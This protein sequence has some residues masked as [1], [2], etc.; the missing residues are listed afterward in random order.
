MKILWSNDLPVHDSSKDALRSYLSSLEVE[1]LDPYYFVGA[2]DF[3]K[4]VEFVRSRLSAPRTHVISDS[5]ICG[6]ESAGLKLLQQLRAEPNFGKGIVLSE[7]LH[8]SVGDPVWQTQRQ[9]IWRFVGN[10][11]VPSGDTCE[12][13]IRYFDQGII[14]FI[15]AAESLFRRLRL[16]LG[17]LHEVESAEYRRFLGIWGSIGGAIEADDNSLTLFCP[18]VADRWNLIPRDFKGLE[19]ATGIKV[20]FG[21]Q[22]EI[23][24]AIEDWAQ[25]VCP[26]ES[27]RRAASWQ[28]GRGNRAG[29]AFR[30]LWESTRSVGNGHAV[31]IPAAMLESADSIQR[32]WLR[33]QYQRLNEQLEKLKSDDLQ[34]LY[35][36]A[37]AE[38]DRG[39]EILTLYKEEGG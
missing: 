27:L 25:I 26:F 30:L 6:D 4:A 23:S 28:S 32:D 3:K 22:K 14:S 10:S 24:R 2:A 29:G 11:R 33:I 19:Q 1:I 35:Q 21:S 15:P 7:D 9:Q 13:I 31:P 12:R 18:R 36:D 34:A 37:T 16:T 38:V 20:G 8:P 17:F 5:Q 39:L